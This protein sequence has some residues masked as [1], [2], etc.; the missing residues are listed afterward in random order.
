[1]KNILIVFLILLLNLGS[2][3]AQQIKVTVNGSGNP[4][5]GATVRLLELDRSSRTDARGQ[6]VFANVP[7][8]IYKIFI[9]VI[10]YASATNTVRVDGPSAETTFTLHESAIGIEEV[11]VSASPYPRTA[12][13]QYQSAESKSMVELHDS[14]GSSFAEQ[15][16]DLPGVTVRGNGSAPSRPILR[17]LSDNRVLI[18]ENGL[19]TGDISTFDPAHA[20]PIDALSISQIDVVRG[21]ASILYGPSTIGGL[22]NVITNTI[23]AFSTNPFSGRVSLAGNSVSDEYTGYFDGVYSNGG[24]ALGISAGGV[25]SQDIHIP[26]GEYADPA[27]GQEFNLNRMPQS[28][29]HTQEG[30]IGYSYQNDFGMIGIGGKHYEMNYG[31]PGVPPNPNW[32]NVPPATS[33]ITQYK[34]SL[35]MRSLFVVDGSLIKQGTFNTNY[36]DYKHSE[37]PTAE[38]STGVSDPQANEF[39]KQAFNATLQFEHQQFGKFQGAAGLWTNIENLTIEGD[40]P[41][42][43]N[44]ITTGIAGYAYEE[45]L[46]DENTRLQVGVRYDFNRIQ[47][48]PYAAS[49]DSVFQVLDV[50]RRSNA[51]TASVGAIEKVTQELTASLSIARSFRPPTV[52]ELFANGLDAAS[53]TYSIGDASLNPETGIGVDASLKG[54][55]TNVS[56]ELSPYLNFINNY[57]YAFLT[58]D[59]LQ[60]FPV[61]QFSATDARLEGFEALVMVQPMQKIAVRASVDFVNAEDT[62]N[63][64]PLPFTPPM[65]GLLRMIYQDEMYSGMVEWRLA[66]RQTRLGDGDTPTAGYGVVNLGVGIRF[67]S[68]EIEHTMSIH[69]DNL[70]NL[71]YR[72]NLSVIKDF[73]PQP[74]RGVRL[75]YD[76]VF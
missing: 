17:G 52:Q 72:D 20:V 68:K 61:R 50:A 53:A 18:L 71:V 42:G 37:Y 15:I 39:H 1:M 29:D 65:R 14:P 10:G 59:T 28:F 67:A 57:I 62:K 64:I 33:R 7:K 30:S 46:A 4:I 70:F 21:P 41:L 16:S 60:A 45:Y 54:S 19:R 43:P 22:V 55:F 48:K 8:G 9:R 74:A 25:H 38:D 75:N 73:L 76:L 27:S 47:T 24:H 11:V 66:A 58:G 32:M 56:F 44:S 2:L 51:V 34:N 49:T 63:N 31:I 35:E 3:Y 5:V 23:P 13:D 69:C 26:S 40:M 36:V 12:D 6:A